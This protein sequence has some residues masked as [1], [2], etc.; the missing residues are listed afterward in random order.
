MKKLLSGLFFVLTNTVHAQLYQDAAGI[1][2][3]SFGSS[4][5]QDRELSDLLNDRGVTLTMYD[6]WGPIG[7]VKSKKTEFFGT[8]N[9]SLLNIEYEADAIDPNR[10]QRVYDI[11]STL[12]LRH[13]I[14]DK[15]S[16]LLL[17]IPSVTSDLKRRM[18]SQDWINQGAL[19]AIRKF[20]AA[21]KLELGAGLFATYALGDLQFL[22]AITVDYVSTNQKWIVQAYWPRL[23]ALYRWN[24]NNEIGL[25]AAIDGTNYNLSNYTDLFGN[26]ISSARFSIIRVGPQFDRRL[27]GNFWFQLQGG[28]AV[29][30]TYQVE[31]DDQNTVRGGEY[32]LEPT[33]YVRAMTTYRFNQ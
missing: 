8:V 9:G 14:S 18:S 13:S 19:V 15:W 28:L 4:S 6:I 20:K 32:S 26:Q 31:D 30:N 5:L 16:G 7:Y 22:P 17:Y 23:N 29:G 3:T 33:W 12:F 21:G 2:V 27:V 10:P 24:P 25:A 11:K 1:A